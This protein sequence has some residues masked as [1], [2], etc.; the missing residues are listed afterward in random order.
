MLLS[1]RVIALL[2]SFTPEVSNNTNCSN[3]NNKARYIIVNNN[4][5]DVSFFF[6]RYTKMLIHYTPEQ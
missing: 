6:K 4:K 2:A 1:D 5:N 3:T